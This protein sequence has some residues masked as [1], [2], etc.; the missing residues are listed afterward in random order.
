LPVNRNEP[1][2]IV[3]YALIQGDSWYKSVP[4]EIWFSAACRG[5]YL[6]YTL[7]QMSEATIKLK[8]SYERFGGLKEIR[9]VG[10]D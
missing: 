5:C 9:C 10:V 7:P 4:N 1:V 6:V 2:G 3:I 8:F